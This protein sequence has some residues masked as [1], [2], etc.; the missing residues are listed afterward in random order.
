MHGTKDIIPNI[1]HTIIKYLKLFQNRHHR[2]D[3]YSSA[4][5]LVA[6]V[7]SYAG[8]PVL[9]PL[10]GIVVSMMLV[11][12][13]VGI[14]GSSI[15][16]L[17]DKGITPEELTS[18]Q[19][20]IDKVKENELD[21]I[22]FHSVRGRKQGPYNQVD[23]VLQLNPDMSMQKAHQLEQKVRASVK[24]H[25]ENVENVLI[26]LEDASIEKDQDHHH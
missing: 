14:L 21:L 6:I 2:S 3:A 20:A 12:S 10:G 19:S 13:S 1:S 7:G 18:I 16:E 11:N 24:S 9:D 22:Q 26:Y 4:V 8:M 25:C 5:A 15:K 17:M 23:L